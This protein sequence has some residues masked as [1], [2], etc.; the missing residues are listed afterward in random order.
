MK[1]ALEVPTVNIF[2]YKMQNDPILAYN[3]MAKKS[4]ASQKK[5]QNRPLGNYKVCPNSGN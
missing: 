3:Q 5:A 4:S 1:L 2:R